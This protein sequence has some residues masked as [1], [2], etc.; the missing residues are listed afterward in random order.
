MHKL[1]INNA[2][3]LHMFVRKDGVGRESDFVV[4]H[5]YQEHVDVSALID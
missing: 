2:N 4:E 5:P 1:N 3:I